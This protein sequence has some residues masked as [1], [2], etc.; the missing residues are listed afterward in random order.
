MNKLLTVCFLVCIGGFVTAAWAFPF[1]KS[2]HESATGVAG[3]N[4]AG[5]GGFYGTGGRTDK[6]IKCSHCHI[7]SE[8]KVGVN[9]TAVPAFVVA[10]ADTKYVPGQRY[11]ITVQLTG[12]H[13]RPG[14]MNNK[15]GMTATIE[16]ASGQRAGRFI[17]DAGQDT[18]A[19]PA[20][21]PYPGG[22]GPVSPVGKTTFMYGDCHGVLPLD[23]PGLTQWVF[24]WVAPAAGAGQLT[25]FI[26]A[27]DGDSDGSSSLDD[28]VAERALQL[29]EGP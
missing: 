12:E 13:L 2:W 7:K 23:H 4:R 28:D 18:N 8:G 26:G 22:A 24:D 14:T 19:C 9:V 17:A 27:V 6:G 15:N 5:A 10:A 29:R 25:L 11:T 1:N 20:T 16:N 3:T 21:N